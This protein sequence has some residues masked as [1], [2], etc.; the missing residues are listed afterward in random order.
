MKYE[1]QIIEATVKWC[2]EYLFLDNVSISIRIKNYDDCWG[3]CVEGEVKKS[4]RITVANN[5]SLRD[6][7]ATVVHEMIHVKQWE[8]GKWHGDGE[9]ECDKRQYN[10]TDKLWK[11]GVI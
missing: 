10:I 5:Q 2:G 4:Y 1:R 11:C 6:F 8:T 7:V 9:E 3:S